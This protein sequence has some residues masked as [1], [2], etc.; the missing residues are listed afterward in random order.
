ADIVLPDRTGRDF[1]ATPFSQIDR[2]LQSFLA[3]GTVPTNQEI[4]LAA[5]IDRT[6]IVEVQRALPSALTLSRALVRKAAKLGGPVAISA[7]RALARAALLSGNYREAEKAYLRVR[8]MP[9]LDLLSRGRI[10]RTLIDVYMYLGDFAESKRRARLALK[11]F[12]K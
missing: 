12:S 10:D 7:Y 2:S 11:T 1:V 8:R 5:C 9:G 3:L 6:I 4:E